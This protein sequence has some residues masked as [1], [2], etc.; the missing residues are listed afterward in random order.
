MESRTCDHL[1]KSKAK[2]EIHHIHGALYRF[3]DPNNPKE[4]KQADYDL[5]PGNSQ[6]GAQAP[7]GR[8]VVLQLVKNGEKKSKL[9]LSLD[10]ISSFLQ[11]ALDQAQI[12]PTTSE[13]YSVGDGGV[14]LALSN[15]GNFMAAWDGREHEDVNMF[16]YRQSV[17]LADKLKDAL[18]NA[19][20]N[21]LAVGLRDD[22]PRGTGHVVNF[23]SNIV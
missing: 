4:F 14:V 15:D 10:N 1:F 21:T 19:I 22:Q 17:E 20:A 8:Q 18:L 9:E 23:M 11:E 6:Y 12:Q 16:T 3:I 7:L 13:K 2:I 5:K